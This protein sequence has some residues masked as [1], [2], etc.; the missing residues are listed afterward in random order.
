MNKNEQ[1]IL[2]VFKP[3]LWSY[4]LSKFDLEAD[5]ERIITNVLNWGTKSA[6]D[7][8]LKI[9]NKNEIKK[10]LETPRPGEWSDKSLN[11]WRLIFN[12]EPIKTKNVLRNFR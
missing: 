7:L 1:E 3:F 6:T 4:D 10:V 8:L 11:Y 9:Y 2:K 12:L 5:K